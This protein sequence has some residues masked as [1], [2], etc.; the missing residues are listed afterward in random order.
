MTNYKLSRISLSITIAGVLIL[1]L[2]SVIFNT[3]GMEPLDLAVNMHCLSLQLL[4]IG[5]VLYF[6][7]KAVKH[8]FVYI[9]IK[10][11][12]WFTAMAIILFLSCMGFFV[13]YSHNNS[14]AGIFLTLCTLF[15]LLYFS[16]YFACVTFKFNDE[17]E[18]MQD[19]EKI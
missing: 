4:N 1:P 9:P 19:Y 7:R 2:V 11:F 6:Y 14:G 18:F 17:D 5:L 15:E 13:S 8:E 16:I 3:G 12:Q 10:V